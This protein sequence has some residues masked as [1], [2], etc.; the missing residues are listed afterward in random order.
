MLFYH[1]DLQRLI[2]IDLK[3]GK[4]KAEYKGKMELYLKWLN[5]YERRPDERMPL[6]I[7]L[8]AG[9]KHE[10]IELLE[11]GES[12]IHVADYCKEIPSQEV[13]Q[14]QFRRAIAHSKRRLEHQAL[15]NEE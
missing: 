9:K 13:L 11:L 10:Q 1:R 3:L 2:C 15:E 4:F 5:R 7:I 6:G 14:K 12:G 8:C